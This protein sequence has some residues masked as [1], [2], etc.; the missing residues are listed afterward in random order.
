MITHIW[1][2]R[3]NWGCGKAFC[4]AV[5]DVEATRL[6]KFVHLVKLNKITYLLGLSSHLQFNGSHYVCISLSI[7]LVD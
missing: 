3:E 4:L 2:K 5:P 1:G 6:Y 7:R